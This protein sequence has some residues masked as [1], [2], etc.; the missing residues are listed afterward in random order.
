MV[1]SPAK[2]Q[3]IETYLGPGYKVMASYGHLRTLDKLE[4]IDISHGFATTYSVLQE[5]IK[6]KQIEKIRQAIGNAS[7]VILATDDDREGESIAWHICDLFGLSVAHTKRIIFHEITKPAIQSAIAHPTK[8]NMDLVRAQQ[9]RQI[10]DLLVGYTISPV[11]WHYVAKKHDTG[12]SAGRCQTP[13]LRLIYENYLDIKNSPTTIA[14]NTVGYFTNLNLVFE[15]NKQFISK[16]DIKDFLNICASSTPTL[17]VNLNGNCT[18]NIC[19]KFSFLCTVSQPKKVIKEASEPLTTSNLQQMASNELNLGPKETMKYAQQLYEK[20]YITYMRTDSKKYS[21][22][23]IDEAKAYIAKNYEEKYIRPTLDKMTIH[24]TDKT[25]TIVNEVAIKMNIPPPQE[26][27]E[28]IRPANIAVK[29]VNSETTDLPSKAVRL[30]ELIWQRTL[31]SCMSS[32]QYNTITANICA[33]MD[34]KFVYRAEQVVFL[35]WQIVK[36]KKAADPSIYQYLSKLKQNIELTPKKIESQ[37]TL[38]SQKSHYTEA[39]MV[40]LLEQRGIGRPSTFASIIDKIQERKYVEKQNIVGK[41]IEEVD[42]ILKI[43]DNNHEIEETLTTK[44]FGNEKN[45]LVIQ[46]LGIIVIE[47]LLSKFNSFFDYEFTKHMEDEL[48]QIATSQLL[49]SN[50]CQKC[51][52]ML[53]SATKEVQHLQKFSIDLGGNHTFVIGKYGPIIKHTDPATNKTT[54]LPVKK[55][56]DINELKKQNAKSVKLEDIV[57]G[58]KQ[59]QDA[60]GKYKGLDL[61]VKK[62]KYGIYA[63]WGSDTR[64]LGGEFSLDK[65]DYTDIIRFLDKET[66]LDPSKPVGLV[67]E[68]TPNLSIRTGK[69]GDYIFYKAAK[70]KKPT[71]FKLAGFNDDYKK[72]D[73][74]LILNWIKLTYNL[75]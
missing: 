40:Q 21:S 73:K 17:S 29:T 20:G 18:D 32:A 63:Q 27:H 38:T 35:G 3:A 44:E 57:D 52:D 19:A 60:I 33:P 15:L 24:D 58:T 66:V 55:E 36:N 9:A 61:F 53:Q 25:K 5:P 47:F 13:T 30:Y 72:C 6:L 1:E 45:K 62:G 28:A 49:W 69:Y 39:R 71:F 41:K 46:P 8:I 64:S 75:P 23:F 31:E 11:L 50:V 2:C 16:K 74:I 59:N 54:F 56:L 7:E 37:F 67:R 43:H 48:D 42:F 26:A 10:L 34:T 68:L 4:S 22:K 14:Y 65:I 12:L 70:A 51:Y